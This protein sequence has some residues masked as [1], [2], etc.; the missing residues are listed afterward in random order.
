MP[1]GKSVDL[2][3]LHWLLLADMFDGKSSGLVSLHLLSI[4]DTLS[5]AL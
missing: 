3:G 5:S 2:V 1:G 4:A